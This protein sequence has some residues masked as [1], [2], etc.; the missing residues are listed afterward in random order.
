MYVVCMW[1]CEGYICECSCR[2]VLL[3]SV[4]ACSYKSTLSVEGPKLMLVAWENRSVDCRLS[5]QLTSSDL[6]SVFTLDPWPSALSPIFFDRP[7]G[8]NLEN[9]LCR[10][11]VHLFT[12]PVESGFL[13]VDLALHTSL[14]IDYWII[15]YALLIHNYLYLCV[16][17][18][19]TA[20]SVGT[21]AAHDSSNW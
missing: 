18:Y 7:P 2:V 17:N 13:D 21:V 6:S 15:D 8:C 19:W 3:A 14:D 20:E 4:V 11:V 5:N 12:V 9:N 10:S 16:A 1:T